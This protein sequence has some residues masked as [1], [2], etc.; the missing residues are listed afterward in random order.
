MTPKRCFFSTIFI[1]SFFLSV[2]FIVF[3]FPKSLKAQGCSDAGFCTIG[4]LKP[5]A[6]T[7][8]SDK[9][10]G[11]RITFL[12][13]FGQGDDDVFVAAP[14]LQ[15]DYF[16][17]TGWNLQ[18][19]I[20]ANYA[21]GSLG[22]ALGAGDIYLSASRANALKN[23]WTF[24]YTAG[25]KIPLNQANASENGMPLP[26]QYQSSLGTLDVIAGATLSNQKWQIS[27]GYQ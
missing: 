19:K 3:A 18:G 8:S 16:T 20:T 12:T 1:R 17:T 25:L 11:Q 15:Y 13:P 27:A 24:T 14:G 21:D 22:T 23:S 5:D 4:P 26:M 10:N 9:K 6:R 2:L 7:L